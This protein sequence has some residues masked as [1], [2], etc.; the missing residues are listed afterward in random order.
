MIPP[1]NDE[2]EK[3]RKTGRSEKNTLKTKDAAKLVFRERTRNL[4]PSNEICD[5]ALK[6]GWYSRKNPY[7][8]MG[9][10]LYKDVEKKGG[11]FVEIGAKFGLRKIKYETKCFLC[12]NKSS[13]EGLL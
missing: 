5:A 13:H 4:C 11:A 9:A 7:H 12:P 1:A 2:C 3:I 6:L 10:M 8:D